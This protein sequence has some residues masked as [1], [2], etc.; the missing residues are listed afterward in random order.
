M[1]HQ[2]SSRPSSNSTVTSSVCG[3]GQVE[4]GELCDDGNTTTESCPHGVGAC[5]VCAE[6][7]FQRPGATS[8]CGDGQRDAV[9]EQCDDGNTITEAC[10]YGQSSCVVCAADCRSVAGATAYC[11]N[12]AATVEE[13]CDD[14]NTLTEACA[15][16]LSSCMVCAADCTAAAGATSFCG[17]T[18]VNGPEGCDDGNSATEACAYGQRSCSVCTAQCAQAGGITSYCGDGRVNGPEGCDDG[19]AQTE[20]CAYGLRSCSVCAASCVNAP[21]P[22]SFCGDGVVNGPESCDDANQNASDGC[23]NTCVEDPQYTCTGSPSVCRSGTLRIENNTSFYITGIEVDGVEYLP[24]GLGIGFAGNPNGHQAF[25]EI[26]VKMGRQHTYTIRNGEWDTGNC[27]RRVYETWGATTWTQPD[28]V[29]MAR[30]VNGR[31]LP[32]FMNQDHGYNYSCWYSSYTDGVNTRNAYLRFNQD[33]TWT[34]KEYYNVSGALITSGGGTYAETGRTVGNNIFHR[35]TITQNGSGTWN[36][37][38]DVNGG[39]YVENGGRS[40]GTRGTRL[41][42]LRQTNGVGG[43]PTNCR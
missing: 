15:Y 30:L 12:G 24:C 23:S 16:G 35:M 10:A 6:D 8:V 4:S 9:N 7:C 37:Q 20:L 18:V 41:V 17:D 25:T 11:G 40:N 28:G 39:H 19:N 43:A 34:F 31:S 29:H 36:G 33:G 21:G 14:G 1:V 2:S 5:L 26:P 32:Q 13:T 38:Y 42:Y 27:T 22:V 3:N